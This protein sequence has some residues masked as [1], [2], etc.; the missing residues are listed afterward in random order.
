MCQNVEAAA[1]K[2]T[3]AIV[4]PKTAASKKHFFGGMFDAKELL[5]SQESIGAAIRFQKEEIKK[6][7]TLISSKD[8]AKNN[9]SSNKFWKD[10]K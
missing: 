10:N 6:F 2:L 4:T 3:E 5:E 1:S 9:L 8:F 7:S